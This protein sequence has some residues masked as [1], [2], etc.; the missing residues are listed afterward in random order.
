MCCHRF[1]SYVRETISLTNNNNGLG[2]RSYQ[3]ID[4]ACLEVIK[5]YLAGRS[6]QI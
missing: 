5:L 2:K 3:E 6:K 1:K 4:S